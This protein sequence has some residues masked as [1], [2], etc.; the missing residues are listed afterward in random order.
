MPGAKGGSGK[1]GGS[2]HASPAAINDDEDLMNKM[3]R[4][5]KNFRTWAAKR[6]RAGVI[7]YDRSPAPPKR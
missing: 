6:K 1:P 7:N 5:G 3:S 2:G 4:R